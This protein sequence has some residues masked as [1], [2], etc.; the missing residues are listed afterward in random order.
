MTSRGSA[1]R[2]GGGELLAIARAALEEA[3]GRRAPRAPRSAPPASG[4]AAVENGASFVTLTIDGRLRGCVGTVRPYRPLAEDV[5]DNA[6]AAAL[7]DSRFPP[8]GADEV[9][10]VRIEVS[11]LSPLEEIP[12]P[13]RAT[14]E[15]ALRPRADG[16]LIDGEGVRAVFLPQVWEGL[17]EPAEFVEHLA[18]KAGLA[19]GEWPAGL[20]AWRFTVE[21]WEEST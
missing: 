12:A 3:V 2:E 5:R 14:L 4:G 9:D 19:A 15:T 6:V 1:E 11:R 13:D 10:A 7:R 17:P 18:R 21:S 16:L 8:L 20:R